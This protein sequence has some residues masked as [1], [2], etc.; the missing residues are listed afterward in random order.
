MLDKKIRRSLLEVKEQKEKD[1]IRETL[2]KNRLTVLVE[3]IKSEEDYNNLSETKRAQLAFNVA[4]ELCYLQTNGLLS[5]SMDLGGALKSIF[6]GFFGNATETFFEPIIK[7]FITPL[8][9]EG[10]MT[11]FIVSYLTKRPSDVIKSLSDCKLMTKLVAQSI[12]ES[13]VMSLQRQ[14]GW[15]GIGY[16]FLRNSLGDAIES[17]GFI[18]GIENSIS[19]TICSLFGKYADNAKK[20]EAK[21]KTA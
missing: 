11:N 9:G 18:T 7:K 21:L 17:T 16:S 13:M 2:I 15:D 10:Y 3:H 6:G 8:F 12:V 14:K 4:N 1:L 5:E 20:V 19:K